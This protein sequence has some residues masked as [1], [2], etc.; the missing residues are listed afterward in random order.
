MDEITAKK[1][2]ELNQ[3]FYHELSDSFSSTRHKAQPGVV[4]ICDNIPTAARVL[5]IGCGNGTFA[6]ALADHGFNGVYVGLDFSDGLLSDAKTSTFPFP[7]YYQQVDLFD[8]N[9]LNAINGEY[10]VIT[11]FA[12]FHH[13]PG[14]L[15][16]V[17]VL[18]R[19]KEL[20]HPNG[21][22]IISN[23]Q[24]LN[25]PKLRSRLHD[26]AEVSIDP[27]SLDEGDY[28]LDWKSGGG[29]LRY[30]HSY[31]QSELDQLAMKAGFKVIDAFLSDG[32]S[33]DLGLYN[34]WEIA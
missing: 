28:L 20:L 24:F 17:R 8:P 31:S 18:S 6:A 27:S 19:A 26:W 10:D 7:T 22:F 14:E 16:R 25:S 11:S 13:I 23:W 5:D 9:Q 2:N 15:A 32:K 33:G 21:K 29:G 12:V 4:K 3:R 1:L 34:V 30:A